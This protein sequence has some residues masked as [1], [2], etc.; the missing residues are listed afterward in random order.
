MRPAMDRSV[1]QPECKITPDR[2]ADR[3][4]AAIYTGFRKIIP[5]GFATDASL[6]KPSYHSGG[7]HPSGRDIWAVQFRQSPCCGNEFI[8]SREPKAVYMGA[9]LTHSFGGFST[10]GR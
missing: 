6:K 5:L 10:K 9:P 2:R 4:R 8:R 1:S 7:A 3:D